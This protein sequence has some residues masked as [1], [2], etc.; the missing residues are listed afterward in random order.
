MKAEPDVRR[1]LRLYQLAL[2]QS[3][4][5]PWVIWM[6]TRP[7]GSGP[8]A[9]WWRLPRITLGTE[10]FVI[11]HVRR[12]LAALSRAYAARA[13]LGELGEMGERNRAALSLFQESL[14]PTRFR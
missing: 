7:H 11:W 8:L 2:T 10:S 3:A 1:L 6:S 14:K 12:S 9:G 13:A 4:E 5:L